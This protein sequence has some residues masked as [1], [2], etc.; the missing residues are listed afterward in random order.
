MRGSILYPLN[1]LLEVYPDL[2]EQKRAKYAGREHVAATYIPG[3]DCYWGDV[4]QM[5]A[6]PAKIIQ[7]RQKTRG[8]DPFSFFEIDSDGLDPSKLCAW[9]GDEFVL[10]DPKL[11]V[12]RTSEEIEADFERRV[13]EKGSARLFI[14]LPHVLYKG[15]ID[16]SSC[17]IVQ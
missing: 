14:L 12:D 11:P 17:P 15:E 10:F 13:R 3:L 6:V 2:Y 7:K 9:V 4:V 1:K 5:F 16:I 8:G